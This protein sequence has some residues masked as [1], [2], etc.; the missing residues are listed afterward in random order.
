MII[1][2]SAN[3]LSA[4]LYLLKK[5]G[6]KIGFVPTMGALHKGHISLIDQSG[7]DNNV[8]VCSIFINPTQFTNDADFQHYPV[9]IESDIEALEGAGCDIL[10]LPSQSEIYNESFVRRHFEL[11]RLEELLEGHFRPGHFQG[12][13][14]V[15]D[16]LLQIV[17]ADRLY[18]GQ[19]D[20]QQ[21]MVIARLLQLTGRE[22]QVELAIVPTVREANGLAMSSR[23]LRLSPADRE[24]ATAIS[25]VLYA[26]KSNLSSKSFTKLKEEAFNF[27]TARG[28]SVDYIEIADAR[29]LEAASGVEQPLVALVAASLGD[30]RLIDN[31]ILN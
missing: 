7:K 25:E 30:I 2:K 17:P 22:K 4:H 18:V 21:C 13:C 6:K 5:E 9:T 31:L 8:T 11:G 27:L 10:F 29:T 16:R 26:T 15:V 12:V 3:G 24:R 1:F 23:N 20:Y 19:K 28:F 14:Q